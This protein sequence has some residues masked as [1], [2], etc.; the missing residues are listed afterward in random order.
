MRVRRLVVLS[1]IAGAFAFAPAATAVAG[2]DSSA[3]VVTAATCP[4]IPVTYMCAP[5]RAKG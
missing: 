3:P 2:T 1:L 4:N 5:V